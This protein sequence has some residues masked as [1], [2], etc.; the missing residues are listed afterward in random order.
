MNIK[1]ACF[2]N[3]HNGRSGRQKGYL[4]RQNSSTPSLTSL[5]PILIHCLSFKSNFAKSLTLCQTINLGAS[6][7]LISP[8][9]WRISPSLQRTSPSSRLISPSPMLLSPSGEYHSVNGDPLSVKWCTLW[10]TLSIG[11]ISLTMS[12]YI[13]QHIAAM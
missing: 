4:K 9:P 7:R 3:S 12:I 10:M 5:R 2:P 1:I 6:P 11:I 8:S 13:I